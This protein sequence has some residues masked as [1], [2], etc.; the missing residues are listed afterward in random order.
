M[1]KKSKTKNETIDFS[2]GIY[3][4]VSTEEQAKEGFSIRS[5]IQKLRDYAR[6]RGWVIHDIY[7]DDGKSG[8]NIEERPELNRLIKDIKKKSVN[9]VLV[10]KLDRLTRS[11]RD[12]L[13]LIE[14]MNDNDC[15]FNSFSE[16]IDTQTASGRMF[17]QIV[18][19]FA[20]FERAN[21]IERVKMGMERKVREGYKICS[22]SASYGYDLKKGEKIQTINQEESEIVKD[23]FNMYVNEH[24]SFSRIAIILNTRG[25]KTKKGDSCWTGATIKAILEN[26]TH[27]GKVRYSIK[28]D[29]NYF[30]VDGHHESII[31]LELFN[32][33]K[34]KISKMQKVSYT[35]RPKEDNYYCG[36][37]ICGE[38]GTKMKSHITQYKKLDGS[39]A[40]NTS[41]Q[42]PKTTVKACTMKAISQPKLDISFLEYIE[43]I[44][45][46]D[47]IDNLILEE[48]ETN[49]RQEQIKSDCEARFKR[50]TIKEKEIIS[51]YT[52]DKIT[53]DEYTKMV[54]Q[55]K[56]DLE[57][58]K[59]E[60]EIIT[61]NTEEEVNIKKEQIIK[62]L[63]ENWKHLSNIERQQFLNTFVKKIVILTRQEPDK[64]RNNVKIMDIE[65]AGV[66]EP[67]KSK[68]KMLIR[69]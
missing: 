9:N 50:L 52:D 31:S 44:D 6:V 43:N 16:N 42:C 30:E 28:D 41:Y 13:D 45:E 56:I 29:T 8:K 54:K 61:D 17:L 7:I 62:E 26:P 57:N 47:V 5:Q 58:I 48:N 37:L 64:K 23:I 32:Q 34:N 2:T 21:M 35:K 49:K 19:I 22:F 10:Y 14:L 1:Q 4:R 27:I 63:K 11:L 3:V 40:T 69:N 66:L 33:A 55:V 38:C 15:T 68:G 39:I 60:L 25:I 20:E 36:V 18:G 24:K 12:L 67:E 59:N 53:F 46:F 65:F 51:L